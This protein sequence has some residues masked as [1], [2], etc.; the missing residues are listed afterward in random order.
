MLHVFPL[1]LVSSHDR[2]L[3]HSSR[4]VFHSSR[5]V[6]ASSVGWP[7]QQSIGAVRGTLWSPFR[8]E[9]CTS[10][11][12]WASFRCSSFR[13]LTSDYRLAW[14]QSNFVRMRSA[15]SIS[16]PLSTHWPLSKLYQLACW[17]FV[18]CPIWMRNS[19]SS[20][21]KLMPWKHCYWSP[22][23]VVLSWSRTTRLGRIQQVARPFPLLSPR[24]P[25]LLSYCWGLILSC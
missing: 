12:S 6:S 9:S 10:C 11:S 25:T 21:R 7:L 22:R 24:F 13:L 19:S 18:V 1:W 15:Q 5:F 8:P 16:L 23:G 17:T 14:H 2:I 4:T 3:Y 20:Q